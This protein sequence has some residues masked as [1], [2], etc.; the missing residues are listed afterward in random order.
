MKIALAYGRT[1]LQ[2]ELPDTAQVTVVE[3]AFREGV[4][5][6]MAALAEALRHPLAARPLAELARPRDTVGIVFSDITRPTPN[7]LLIPALCRALAHLPDAQLLLFNATGTHRPN[8]DTELRGMLGD[9]VVERF[10]IIQNDAGDGD[11]HRYVGTTRSGNAIALLGEFLDCDVRILTGFIEPHFFAGFSG[12]GKAVMPGLAALDCIRTN[13]SAR[14]LD[15]P[16]ATWGV[17]AGNPLWEEIHQA[18][19]MAAPDF[20]LNVT[21]NRHKEITAV[22]AGDYTVAHAQ[23][24]AYAKATAMTP[25]PAPFDI[26]IA[27]NSGYP[28]DLNLYQSVKGMSAA[29]QVVKPGGSI[30]IAA[31]CWDGI[32][33]HGEYHRL[34]SEASSLSELLAMVRMPGFSCQDMWQAQIHAQIGLK[35]DVYFHSGN[36]SEE[37]VRRA[38]LLPC[39]RIE[40]TVA[41][42]LQKYGPEASI[43]VL[44]EGP[45]TIPFVQSP[46]SAAGL[47][48]GA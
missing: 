33:A 10:R 19:L 8:T 27:S 2:V 16:A 5:D 1:G 38:L 23:G 39:A 28:L 17:T 30:I 6:P 3:P 34:L 4:R 36:L 15:D 42:L 18:G 21:L 20:L 41:L 24:C 45:Q 29:A 9:E 40:D 22:F 35:A 48:A 12:G 13:H 44:P 32:P 11:A 37:Q 31:D 25:V 46:V 26:V 43:C 14:Y 47:P 7:H